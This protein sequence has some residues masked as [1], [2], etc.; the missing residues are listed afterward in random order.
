M[1]QTRKGKQWFFGMKLHIGVDARTGLAHSAV[2]TAANVHDKHPLPDLLHGQE[3]QVWGDCAYSSQHALIA[4]AAPQAQD[5]TIRLVRRAAPPRRSSAWSTARSPV[6]GPGSNTSSPSSSGCGASTR[7][8]TAAWPRMPTE[9]L[10]PRRWPTCS[11]RVS[12]CWHECVRVAP[13]RHPDA[14][15]CCPAAPNRA[16]TASRRC[17]SLRFRSHRRLFSVASRTVCKTRRNLA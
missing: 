12:A 1:H 17:G 14:W 11:W 10:S 3:Q 5:M 6:C 2:V 15:T 8:A 13:G 7:F 4:A 9:R 16:S